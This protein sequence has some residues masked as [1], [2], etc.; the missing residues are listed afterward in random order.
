[1]GRV[2]ISAKVP[3]EFAHAIRA[4]AEKMDATISQVIRWL[5]RDWL[6][7]EIEA[8]PPQG[9]EADDREE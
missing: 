2:T 6:A 3:V 9:K 8:E 7:G 4:R 5:L 1:M